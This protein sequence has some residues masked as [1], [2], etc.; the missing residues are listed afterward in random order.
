VDFD[1]LIA[2]LT[3]MSQEQQLMIPQATI[4]PSATPGI[5]DANLRLE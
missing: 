2:W 4:T 1:N 5:V 3:V